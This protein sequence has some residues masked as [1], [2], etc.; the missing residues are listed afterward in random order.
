MPQVCPLGEEDDEGKTA[1][2]DAL[3]S[4]MIANT[5]DFGARL[6]FFL[7]AVFRGEYAAPHYAVATAR[8]AISQRFDPGK[9]AIPPSAKDDGVSHARHQLL[10]DLK[11]WKDKNLRWTY[12][13]EQEVSVHRDPFT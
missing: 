4:Y 3:T 1:S 10:F 13:L 6:V 9:H 2:Y 11:T 12:S 5:F 8:K 7:T